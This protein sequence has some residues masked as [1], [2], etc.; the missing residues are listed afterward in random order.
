MRVDTSGKISL[1]HIYTQPDPRAYFTTLRELDYH[2]PQLARPHFAELIAEYRAARGV[3]VPTVLDLGCSYGINAALLKYGITMGELYQRYGGAGT[4][5]LTRDALL[6]R[7]RELARGG[8]R[9]APAR[10]LGL[11]ASGDALSYALDAGFLDGAVHADLESDDPTGPQRDLLAQAD[12]VISTGCLGYVTERTIARLVAAGGDRRPWM[13]HFIL[14]MFPFDPIAETLA[15]AG[16]E[17]VRR[18]GLFRQ[19]RFATPQERENVLLRLADA[20]I[21][22]SGLE[23]DGWYYAELHVSRPRP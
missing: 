21:D 22:P 15:A 11:D 6:A 13:A 1:D 12:L 20:G 7:D 10:F 5:A 18:E 2:I 16:Y 8:P 23:S 9:T 3:A 14:R 17:T 19:R 4:R